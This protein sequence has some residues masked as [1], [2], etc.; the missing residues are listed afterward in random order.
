LLDTR[1][2]AFRAL[3]ALR[4]QIDSYWRCLTLPFPEPGIRLIP[5]EHVE[6]FDRRMADY[7]ARL[8][9]A[10]ADLERHLDELKAE[11]ARRLG[12]LF[13]PSDY[14]TTLPGGFAVSWDFPNPEPP[15]NLAWLSPSVYQ[16]QEFRIQTRFEEAVRLAERDFFDEF[17]SLVGHLCE[18]ISGADPDGTPKVFRDGAVDNLEEFV[19]RYRRFNLR[20]EV[21]LDE[22]VGLVQ[23]TLQAVTPERL[24]QHPGLRRR[25]AAQLSWAAT[26]LDAMRDDPPRR[27]GA[28][29][30]PHPPAEDT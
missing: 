14:A 6:E 20:S 10:A 16:R 11:A 27:P 18:R 28:R 29:D 30:T 22:M 19:A 5:L 12:S 24:R 13:Q 21:R 1:H 23:Q 7:S 15:S 17:A 26:S 9:D 25:V 3:T 8:R 4:G 2:P